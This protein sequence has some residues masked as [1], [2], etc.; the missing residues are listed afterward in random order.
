MSKKRVN[1]GFIKDLVKSPKNYS[2]QKKDF[3]YSK[4]VV[5]PDPVKTSSFNSKIRGKPSSN[6][7]KEQTAEVRK[8]I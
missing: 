1:T 8:K 6:L 5:K 3:N 7:V 2:Y 4:A